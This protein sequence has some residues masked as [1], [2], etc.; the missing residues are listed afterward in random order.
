MRRLLPLLLALI[1][2]L[3]AAS[4]AAA[5]VDNGSRDPVFVIV[6]DVI[7]GPEQ[8]VEDVYLVNGHARIAGH[9]SGDVVI[10]DGD[11]YLRGQIDDD[12]VMVSG[13]AHLLPGSSVGGNVRYGD[14]PPVIAP[15]ARVGGDVQKESW[16]DLPG[17][18]AIVGAFV[19]WLAVGISAAIL[20][21]LLL[22]LAPRAAEAIFDEAQDRFW[23]A[24]GIGVGITIAIPVAILLA[25]VT[26]VGLPL[27]I[28]LGFAALPFAAVAYVT[29]A[30]ALGRVV[31]KPPRSQIPAF[32]AGLAILR[33]LALLPAVGLLVGL[34]AVI[35]GFGLLGAA[36]GAARR[37]DA[38]H[39]QGT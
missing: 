17:A 18:Y 33:L 36:I 5:K 3:L 13:Q 31:V 23:T 12:L 1:A 25:A 37:P 29:S 38:A 4:P 6:G 14:K 39:A 35:V 28:G 15:T 21:I 16:S 8:E 22:I 19:L 7:I 34:V 20:G 27:A 10:V 11:L 9:V 2:A 24:V 32:L 26:L 30:W